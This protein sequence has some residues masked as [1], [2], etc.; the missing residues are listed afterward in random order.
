MN[1]TSARLE[2]SSTSSSSTLLFKAALVSMSG[3]ETASAALAVVQFTKH[4]VTALVQLLR[5]FNEAGP[6]LVEIARE[7]DCFEWRLQV[8]RD[9]W[10]IDGDSQEAEY[11]LVRAV[12][13]ESGGGSIMSQLA[14]IDHDC[15]KFALLMAKR[16][17]QPHLVQFNLQRQLFETRILELPENR[18]E[19]RL[20]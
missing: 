13:G 11:E 7:F 15:K 20:P 5:D 3:F 12:W 6:R 2:H 16:L 10:F 19:V 14:S 1:S 17:G 8:W 18:N 4:T 9:T